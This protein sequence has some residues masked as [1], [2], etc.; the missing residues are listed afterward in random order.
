MDY[1]SVRFLLKYAFFEAGSGWKLLLY[2]W[3]TILWT[4]K[5]SEVAYLLTN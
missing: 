3:F 2:Y 1:I 4:E 5:R